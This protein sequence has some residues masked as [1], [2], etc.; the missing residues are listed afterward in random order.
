M[1]YHPE[2]YHRVNDEGIFNMLAQRI[3]AYDNSGVK[4]LAA[5]DLQEAITG[6]SAPY[7]FGQ[8]AEHGVYSEC[9]DDPFVY[10]CDNLD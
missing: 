7:G 5:A 6:E 9:D 4:A 2:L 8:C 3:C 1:E 10:K